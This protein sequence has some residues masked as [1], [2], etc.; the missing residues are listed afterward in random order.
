M[1]LLEDIKQIL[2]DDEAHNLKIEVL[3]YGVGVHGK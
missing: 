3:S 1:N 2:R